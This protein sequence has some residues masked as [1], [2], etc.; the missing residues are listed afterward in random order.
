[1]ECVC[2]VRGE[3]T[4]GVLVVEAVRVKKKRERNE[5]ERATTLREKETE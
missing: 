2:V 1:M 3:L 4:K 5:S